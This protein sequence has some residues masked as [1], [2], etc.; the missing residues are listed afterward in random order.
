M[1]EVFRAGFLEAIFGLQV[2][3]AVW[4]PE[5]AGA[6]V[7]E[8]PGWPVGILL[9]AEPKGISYED[10]V[11]LHHNLLQRGSVAGSVDFGEPGF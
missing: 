4:Q 3:I 7:G 1:L 5:A 8:H 11:H 9:A 10:V 2:V 6:D